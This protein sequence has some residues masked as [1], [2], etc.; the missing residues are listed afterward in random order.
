MNTEDNIRQHR[1]SPV[2]DSIDAV[3]YSLATQSVFVGTEGAAPTQD[4]KLTGKIRFK[5][6]TD[7]RGRL[8]AYAYTSQEEF[9]KAFPQGG[10]FAEMKFADVFTIIERDSRFGGIYLNSASDAMYPIP[11][12]LFN[13]VKPIVGREREGG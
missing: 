10:P 13:R 4:G 3:A 2:G 1:K 5:T 7:N 8:W 12:E 6:G 9:S 11:R